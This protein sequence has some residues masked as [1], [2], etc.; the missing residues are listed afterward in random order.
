MYP[1]LLLAE[2]KGPDQTAWMH[3]LILG[4][5]VRTC[6][7]VYLRMTR[8]NNVA[9]NTR[10]KKKTNTGLYLIFYWTSVSVPVDNKNFRR[11]YV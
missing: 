3:M 2:S 5:A 4:F 7:K 6:S 9:N 11:L 1:M 8:P 10:K